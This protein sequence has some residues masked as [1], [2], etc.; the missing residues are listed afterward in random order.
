MCTPPHALGLRPDAAA[1]L[2]ASADTTE[3]VIEQVLATA[4][5]RAKLLRFFVAWLEIDDVDQFDIAPSAFPE[6]TPE[7]AE[8]LLQETHSFLEHQ[9]GSVAPSLKDVTQSTSPF[10]SD[11]LSAIYQGVRASGNEPVELDPERRLGIFTQPAFIASHSGPETTRLIKRGVFFTRKVMCLP[12]GEPP[13]NIDTS[14]PEIAGATERERIESATEAPVCAACHSVINPFGFMLENYDPLGRW[15][16]E[17]ASGFLIDASIGVDF[18][19]EG[20]LYATSPVEALRGFT[21]SWAF[22]Q[23]FTRQLFRFYLGRPEVSSDDPV[24][25]ELFFD[26]ANGERQ[27]LVDML[28]TLAGSSTFAR[29]AETP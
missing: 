14:L 1:S 2:L 18:L 16:D 8:A 13:T 9:L 10:V 28:S 11:A 20:P 26:F 6:F 12:L 21:D 17:D 24:L 27:D 4:E 3:Q 7:L 22:Q 19:D 15:R 29:R 5:A 23:C 25:R